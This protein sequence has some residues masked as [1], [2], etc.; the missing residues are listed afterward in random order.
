MFFAYSPFPPYLRFTW[1]TPRAAR[2]ERRRGTAPTRDDARLRRLGPASVFFDLPAVFDLDAMLAGAPGI[3]WQPEHGA[4]IGVLDRTAPHDPVRWFDVDP[5]YVFH[6]LN[7][8]DDGETVVVDGC[9]SARMNVSFGDERIVEAVQPSLHRWRMD[10]AAA[11][12]R[13]AA[14]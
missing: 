5:F 3:R 11:R 9:R 10:P 1:Q 7:A 2:R 14:R 4:R 13:R 8:F 6:F 12:R